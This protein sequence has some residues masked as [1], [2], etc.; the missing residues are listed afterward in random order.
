MALLNANMGL[1]TESINSSPSQPTYSNPVEHP[2]IDN[3]KVAIP[4]QTEQLS[5]LDTHFHPTSE[6][7]SPGQFSF[8]TSYY[9]GQHSTSTSPAT[10]TSGNLDVQSQEFGFGMGGGP[11][12][13]SY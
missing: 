1:L 5:Y 10:Y 9:S 11:G 3:N 8:N 12:L 13:W 6:F 7:T 2:T 4:A